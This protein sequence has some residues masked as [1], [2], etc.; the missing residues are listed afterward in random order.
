[1]PP[2]DR[3]GVALPQEY[4]ELLGDL[5]E[6]VR[7]LKRK[8][9]ENV[10][11][12]GVSQAPPVVE[13][14]WSEESESEWESDDA[15]ENINLIDVDISSESRPAT[16]TEPLNISFHKP[17]P[18]KRK[19]TVQ[20]LT[21]VERQLRMDVHKFHLTCLLHLVHVR[22]RWCNDSEIHAV[23]RKVLPLRILQE[24]HPPR[25]LSPTL[26]SK[27]F[28]EGLW[29]SIGPW[30]DRFVIKNGGSHMLSWS[31]I[32][33]PDRVIRPS[34][35][36]AAF[37]NSLL[38]FKGSSD[39]YSMGYCAMLR[40]IGIDARLVWS[41][42][43]LD[44]RSNAPI[45]GSY[46]EFCNEFR[47]FKTT[48]KLPI[49][50]VPVIWVEA[51]DRASKRWV[52]VDPFTNTVDYTTRKKNKLEP[53]LSDTNNMMRY[54]IAAD[55]MGRLVDVTR[56]YALYYSAKTIK[57]RVDDDWLQ[58]ALEVYGGS[59][60]DLETTELQRKSTAEPMPS[61]VQDF[62]NHPVFALEAQ[63]RQDEILISKKPCGKL[64][65]NNKHTISIYHR[66][67]VVRLKSARK[68]YQ[69][70]RVLKPGSKPMKYVKAK[71]LKKDDS[72][73]ED[74]EMEALYSID[75]TD[76]FVPSPV[77]NGEIPKN[78]YGN[79][80]LYTPSMIPPGSVYLR[81]PHIWRAA[82]SLD[83]DFADA[84]TGFDYN[85]R[86]V[87]PRKDGIVVARE[88][89]EA[90][91]EVYRAM[92]EQ[93]DEEQRWQLEYNALARWRKYIVA[94]RIK[95][96]LNRKYGK[97]DISKS[98]SEGLTHENGSDQEGGFD[99]GGANDNE[100]GGFYNEGGGF[101]GGFEPEPGSGRRSDDDNP[102]SVAIQEPE[103]GSDD[104][105]EDIFSPAGIN[106]AAAKLV[107]VL[108]K[109]SIQ[110]RKQNQLVEVNL[111]D[112]T[113]EEARTPTVKTESPIQE[114][115]PTTYNVRTDVEGDDFAASSVSES[116]LFDQSDE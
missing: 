77:T 42:Q 72:E 69:A 64:A 15:W 12:I 73:A 82:K 41:I 29:H 52:T 36:R 28:L 18:A 50:S 80:D 47:H 85:N 25:H 22:S 14:V 61:S 86:R 40:S 62:R 39:T 27:K 8:R 58:R 68:W 37:R 101:E 116:E 5:R 43:P 32:Y 10:A 48:K 54:V 106:T 114:V 6:E 99:N 83:I 97:V 115:A 89:E 88:H 45:K 79:I 24:L 33:E 108:Q 9:D 67:D 66:S 51:L 92:K 11:P 109:I 102:E 46:E 107:A 17:V 105:Q 26:K 30:N 111:W 49:P 53:A 23:Y 90:V 103:S 74:G 76:L 16:P 84:V 87:S 71:G 110:P 65:L 60:N 34:Q 57:K 96:R 2:K 81:Y 113:T 4:R 75:Q 19:R 100:G 44:F 35:D 3:D 112:T 93:A 20:S 98:E 95:E 21:K 55:A 13:E 104:T 31:D 56:R 59:L 78:A 63:L 38:L 1:M 70:G 7:K 94:L 91:L